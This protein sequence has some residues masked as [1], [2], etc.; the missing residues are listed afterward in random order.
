MEKLTE[1]LNAIKVRKSTKQV[2][3]QIA[4][5]EQMHIQQVCRRLLCNAIKEYLRKREESSDSENTL[6]GL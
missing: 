5:T 1:T 3:I 6:F 4:E 2:I